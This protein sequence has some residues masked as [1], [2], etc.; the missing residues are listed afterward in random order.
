MSDVREREE[1]V[2]RARQIQASIP[3]L[4]RQINDLV[5]RPFGAKWA[6]RVTKSLQ[7]VIGSGLID[8]LASFTLRDE[9]TVTSSR[10]RTEEEIEDFLATNRGAIRERATYEE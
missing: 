7:A 5:Q 9:L 8:S 6:M 4:E 1:L 3:E 10:R 2:A